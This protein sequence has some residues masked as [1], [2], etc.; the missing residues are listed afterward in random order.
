MLTTGENLPPDRELAYRSKVLILEY[1]WVGS[2]G[3]AWMRALRDF[4]TRL[5]MPPHS[6]VGTSSNEHFI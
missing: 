6:S 5:K 4:V 2:V 1:L 3:N